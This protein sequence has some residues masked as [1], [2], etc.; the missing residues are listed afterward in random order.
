MDKISNMSEQDHIWRVGRVILFKDKGKEPQVL[1]ARGY[2]GAGKDQVQC[3]FCSSIFQALADR[4][5]NHVA[6]GGVGSEPAH[7]KPCAGVLPIAGESPEALEARKKA[8]PD[9]RARFKRLNEEK[10]RQKEENAMKVDLNLATGGE[11]EV[12]TSTNRHTRSRVRFRRLR[13]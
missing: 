10:A 7:I 13:S 8:F 6:G 11:V 2:V 5:R 3:V 4:L 9:A 1:Q 12:G